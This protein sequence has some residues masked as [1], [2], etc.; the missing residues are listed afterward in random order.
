M[1]QSVKENL[2]LVF[3]AFHTSG[4]GFAFSPAHSATSKTKSEL[5]PDTPSFFSA[6]L[7]I[8]ERR[9]QRV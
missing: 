7:F 9:R 3:P 1:L 6:P 2:S 4:I 5:E 8:L